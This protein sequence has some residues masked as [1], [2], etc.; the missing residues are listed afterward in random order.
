ML[1]IFYGTDEI[2][3]REKAQ[4]L[5]RGLQQK[6]PEAELV[7]ITQDMVHSGNHEFDI[8]SLLA[9]QGLFKHNYL[10]YLDG[11]DDVILRFSDTQLRAMKQSS[12]ICVARMGKLLAKDK[13]TLASCANKMTEYVAEKKTTSNMD[14]FALAKALKS[15]NKVLL[16]Q[17]ITQAHLQ[18]VGA[19]A[20]V[21]MLFW[22][23]K[24]MLLKKQF[25]KYSEYELRKMVVYLAE[26]P[27]K[28]RI[29]A[30]SIHNAIE[31][32]VLDMI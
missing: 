10:L 3:V 12:H 16:W 30:I 18:G 17:G 28:S 22:A 4:Q 29:N 25:G 2:K 14:M 32:F 27:H 13:K 20:I 6:A 26:L 5:L 24:D 11:I 15:R 19:E 7:R 21:G 23:V 8:E 1:Y 31:K 9:H